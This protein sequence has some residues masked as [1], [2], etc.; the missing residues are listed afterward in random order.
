[1]GETEILAQKLVEFGEAP[2]RCGLAL[3]LGDVEFGNIGTPTRL[4]FTVI[5]PAVN[6][7]SRLEGLTK[8][9]GRHVV[10]S[11]SF[12]AATSAVLEPLGE[13]RLRGI[14]DPVAVFGL[15]TPPAARPTLLAELG[16]PAAR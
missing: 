8:E 15:P 7:A 2:L 4:D 3:H 5:G 12:A 6:M 1:M 16:Q 10:A 14:A 9:I 11:A 13:H